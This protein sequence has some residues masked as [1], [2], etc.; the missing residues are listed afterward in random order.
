MQIVRTIRAAA[1]SFYV[2][3]LV[4]L[5]LV[6]PVSALIGDMLY[7]PLAAPSLEKQTGKIIDEFDKQDLP[8]DEVLR[9]MDRLGL[10]WLYVSDTAGNV[11]PKYKAFAPDLAT[12]GTSSRPLAWHGHRYYELVAKED[13][14]ILHAG[15]R[16]EPLYDLLHGLPVPFGYA[17]FIIACTSLGTF[18]CFHF[19]VSKPLKQIPARLQKVLDGNRVDTGEMD[20][21]MV[22]SQ[23]TG[24]D[25]DIIAKA[26]SARQ[27]LASEV[28]EA[29]NDLREVI[30][31]ERQQKF[32]NSLMAELHEAD[33]VD[34]VFQNALHKVQDRYSAQ[35]PLALAFVLRNGGY[36]L[37]A[38]YGLTMEQTRPLMKIKKVDAFVRP[39]ETGLTAILMDVPEIDIRSGPGRLLT[40]CVTPIMRKQKPYGILVFYVA[41]DEVTAASLQPMLKELAEC[42]AQ[43]VPTMISL[44]AEMEANR[45]DELTGVTKIKYLDSYLERLQV[46]L[47]QD[48]RVSALLLEGDAF[49]QMNTQ[50]GK[51]TGNELIKELCRVVVS[52]VTPNEQSGGVLP[53]QVQTFRVGAAGF[54]VLLRVCDSKKAGLVAERLRRGIEQYH[55]W[56]NGV[57]G[58]TVTIAHATMPENVSTMA[59]LLVECEVTRDYLRSLKKVN[60]T[61]ASSAVPITFRKRHQGNELGGTLNVFQPAA[62]LQSLATARRTGLMEVTGKNGNK[63]TIYVENGAPKKARLKKLTG[64]DAIIEFVSTFEEGDFQ[65]REFRTDMGAESLTSELMGLGNTQYDVTKAL[66]GLLLDGALAQDNITAAKK[67]IPQLG[68]F[69][70][71]EVRSTEPGVWEDLKKL[72]EPPSYA[73]LT[74]MQEMV[75]LGQGA[76]TLQEIVTKKMEHVPTHVALRAAQLLWEQKL[77]KLSPVKML[78]T[79]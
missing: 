10:A 13:K 29:K 70:I 32:V 58:W 7:A 15:Y 4:V 51:H 60:T 52:G 21:L 35:V 76:A 8:P 43:V 37:K 65:F 49:M 48:E 3:L 12:S 17:L 6:I 78:A 24:I 39:L 68:L 31:R 54:F 50:Y 75:K 25:A 30:H 69:L 22:A 72:P 46:V 1:G 41:G 42:T 62:L 18:C 26:S 47:K 5:V 73:E 45:S 36:E 66:E 61:M 20:I 67:S 79:F 64:N 14:R 28:A 40:I 34:E 57:P 16:M 2:K 71:R 11:S 59:E 56:P 23:I 74:A 27:K 63:I 53:M 19:L 9:S 55:S 44:E 33:T 77:V 38:Q